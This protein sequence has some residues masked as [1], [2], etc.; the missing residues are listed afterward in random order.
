MKN[1]FLIYFVLALSIPVIAQVEHYVNIDPARENNTFP[2]TLKPGIFYHQFWIPT[3]NSIMEYVSIPGQYNTFRD[4]KFNSECWKWSASQQDILNR[5]DENN[6]QGWLEWQQTYAERVVVKFNAMP[7]WLSSSDDWSV[8]YDES[9][10][11]FM[12][13]PPED[14]QQWNDAIQA[15]VNKIKNWGLHPYYEIWN[16]PDGMYWQSSDADLIALYK[17][18]ALSIKE[19][20]PLAKVGAFGMHTW[21]RSADPDIEAEQNAFKSPVMGFLP[22][23]IPAIY[24]IL[25]K[26]M[27]SVAN[28]WAGEVPLDFISYHSFNWNSYDLVHTAQQ[29]R[30]QMDESGFSPPGSGRDLTYPELFVSEWQ[31]TYAI[32]EQVFQPGL[33]LKIMDQFETAGIEMNSI[34][35]INDFGTNEEDEFINGWGMFSQNAL[36]KPVFKALLFLSEITK[37]EKRADAD[38]NPEITV[39]SGLSGDT[40]QIL[41]SN[42]SMP[43]WWYHDYYRFAWSCFEKMLY[44]STS[45]YNAMDY[46]GEGMTSVYWGNSNNDYGSVDSI[47]LGL[48]QPPYD[49]PEEM[50][51][52]LSLARSQYIY[53]STA[54]SVLHIINFNLEVENDSLEIIYAVIDSSQNNLIYLYDSLKVYGGYTHAQAIDS[55]QS[56]TFQGGCY[57]IYSDFD[58]MNVAGNEFSLLVNPNTVLFLTIPGIEYS[59]LG[60][61]KPL[62][63]NNRILVYPNPVTAES[64][65]QF[66]T[67]ASTIT[68]MS[69]NDMSGK[70]VFRQDLGFL[71]K[72]EHTFVI[73]TLSGL[74]AG[75][76]LIRISTTSN[77]LKTTFVVR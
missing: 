5:M 70:E 56:C 45:V 71:P 4:N 23:S 35:A 2:S 26:L 67:D 66:E 76:Y 20:D 69:V 59:P 6:L 7:Y 36:I 53:D 44:D 8:L 16:E 15:V 51:N 55:L 40:L 12:T 58:T 62:A 9:W 18:T 34:A 60:M 72:G 19:A 41:V 73:P 64:R 30:E 11:V 50:I 22:D 29:L 74:Q 52:S 13:Y 61:G 32:Q 48:L 54:N 33:F 24:S 3:Q 77:Q 31:T 42:Y 25:Y 21:W 65:V 46:M 14:M 47:I 39:F 38:H 10:R 27:D 63:P 17:N 43:V 57:G 37:N 28:A 68:M 75:V 49:L 1:S